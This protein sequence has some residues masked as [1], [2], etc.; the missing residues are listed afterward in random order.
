MTEQ[1]ERGEDS[2]GE[3]WT[4]SWEQQC[5]DELDSEPNLDDRLPQE[6]Q[7]AVD[8][9]WYSFQT[10]ASAV[11]HLY[12]LERLTGQSNALPLWLAFQ[13]AASS[14][15]KMYKD[16]LEAH[17][18]S[19]E[20]GTQIGYQ[21][22]TRDIVGWVKK[23]RRFI[24]RE[25]LLAFLCGKAPPPRIRPSQMGR[26][27]AERSSP[28][29]HTQSH[30]VV[31]HSVET[32]DDLQ[33]FREA[34]ALQGLNGAMANVGVSQSPPHHSHSRRRHGNVLDLFPDELFA[35]PDSRKRNTSPNDVHMDSPSHKRNRLL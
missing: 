14:V 31:G 29:S 7:F 21:R 24:K 3:L 23:R 28:R 26:S 4:S 10:C 27:S 32:T 15:T 11:T 6:R 35:H 12:K 13:N 22:R 30:D 20:L 25:D 33:P 9:L 16:S 5:L 19:I 1:K 8:K 2:G 17:R 34:L 18:G